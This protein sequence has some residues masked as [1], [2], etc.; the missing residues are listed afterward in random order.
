MTSAL[1]GLTGFFFALLLIA[2]RVPVAVAMGAVGVA[3]YWW[4]NDWTGAAY[5]LGGAPFE[6]IFPYSLSVIPLFVMMGVFASRAGLSRSLFDVINAFCG[7]LRGGL[8]V[9][10]IG[11]SAL[12][13]AICGSSLATVAT[14]GRVALPE[15]KRHG[16]DDSLS[17][18]SVAAGGT[19]GVLIPPS[20]L[21]V[22]YGLLTQTSIGQL[23]IGAL[24][25]GLLGAMLYS[26]AVIVRV[27]FRPSLAPITERK[28]WLERLG[29]LW[30]VWSVALLFFM[31][32]GGIYFGWFSATEAAAVG[33][34]G[35]FVIALVTGNLNRMVLRDAA[36]ETAALTGM[37]FFILIGA[38]LFNYFLEST[39]LPRVLIDLI[40]A[41]GLTSTSALII[42]LLFYLC[43]GCF[44]DSLSM[45]LLT[46]PLVAPIAISLGFDMVWFGILV[47]T[48]AEIGLITP[49]V[50]MNLFVIQ[51]TSPG[52]QQITV[53]KGI[54]PFILADSVR[55]AMLVAFPPLVLYLPGKMF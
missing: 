26:M 41:A 14:I 12:F 45:I 20:V 53:V 25:P 31:V 18:A 40:E 27:W 30:R 23:F 49:P 6:S 50:G 7:H 47:V 15:M 54:L 38:S 13:G 3:G 29:I 43:L 51:A 39:G 42:I 37:I 22:I 5:I 55:L 46:V 2:F 52:L 17:S 32:I 9:T 16:Y 48:V 24:V 44:M 21:L 8:A 34:T 33:A 36:L 11:A 1:L 4:V 35:A 19:L 28:P 10:S